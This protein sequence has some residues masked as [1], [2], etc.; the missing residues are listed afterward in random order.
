MGDGERQGPNH[1]KQRPGTNGRQS[2]QK[3]PNETSDE[4]WRSLWSGVAEFGRRLAGHLEALWATYSSQ[5]LCFLPSPAAC[6]LGYPSTET[7]HAGGS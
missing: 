4:S 7:D 3:T 6:P 2:Q 5:P 1:V